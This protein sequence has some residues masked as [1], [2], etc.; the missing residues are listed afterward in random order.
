MI[1]GFSQKSRNAKF[2]YEDGRATQSSNIN[3]YLVDADNVFIQL[4]GKASDNRPKLTQGNK[5]WDG[6]FLIVSEE[7]REDLIAK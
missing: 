2:I 5:P 4:R 7:E 1:I 6:G 3:G